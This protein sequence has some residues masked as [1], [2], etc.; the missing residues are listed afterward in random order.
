MR[1]PHTCWSCRFDWHE[2]P[3]IH[4]NGFPTTCAMQCHVEMQS[5]NQFEPRETLKR[6]NRC[7]GPIIVRVVGNDIGGGGAGFFIVF[8]DYGHQQRTLP[9]PSQL[10]C[11]CGLTKQSKSLTL[12]Y[13][14]FD[15][16]LIAMSLDQC[17]FMESETLMKQQS[18][19]NNEWFSCHRL[20]FYY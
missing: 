11:H 7:S 10:W 20:S 15:N 6:F 19:P 13:C 12:H 3:R 9:K 16:H 8:N 4:P 2:S 18:P 14:Y 17:T 5:Q 1:I